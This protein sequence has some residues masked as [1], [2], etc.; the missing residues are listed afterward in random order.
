[1]LARQAALVVHNAGIYDDAVREAEARTVALRESEERFRGVFDKGPFI[2]L[3]LLRTEGSFSGY[4]AQMHRRNGEL[5]T[6]LYSSSLIKIG[7]QTYSLNTLQDITV[8]KQ[9]VERLRQSHK[10]ELLGNLAGGIAHDFNNILTGMLGNVELA[11]L[12]LPPAHAA[13]Q[14]IDRIGATAG[15]A[16]NLVR[17]IRTDRDQ[18]ARATSADRRTRGADQTGDD[19][20]PRGRRRGSSRQT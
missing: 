11:R 2:Y 13:R 19:Q 8:Q 7:G 4:E 16:K 12:D 20:R 6:V 17:Q 15:Y 18:T 3:H 14:W 1:M 9:A 10:I 5:F